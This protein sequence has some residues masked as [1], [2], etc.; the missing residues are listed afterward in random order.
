MYLK[1]FIAAASVPIESAV[2]YFSQAPDTAYL[3]GA[4]GVSLN[5]SLA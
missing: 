5:E 4:Y 3:S 2:H 1:L